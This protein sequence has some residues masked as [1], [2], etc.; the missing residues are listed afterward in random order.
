MLSLLAGLGLVS[1]VQAF[2]AAFG[3]PAPFARCCLMSTFSGSS[4]ASVTEISGDTAGSLILWL[5][6]L[7]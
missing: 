1:I 2:L 5:S 3:S 7:F 4:S 6:R